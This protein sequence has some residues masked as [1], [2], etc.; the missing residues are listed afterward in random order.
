MRARDG[1]PNAYTVCYA[2]H[3]RAR[4]RSYVCGSSA[5]CINVEDADMIVFV[6]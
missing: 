4:A 2:A 3:D 6:V 1:S 5:V